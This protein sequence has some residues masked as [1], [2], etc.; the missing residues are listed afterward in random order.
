MTKQSIPNELIVRYHELV[1]QQKANA[2]NKELY[3]LALDAAKAAADAGYADAQYLYADN[4]FRLSEDR[5]RAYEYCCK[6]ALQGHQRALQ[7]LRER[8]NGIG[9][10]MARVQIRNF[11][12]QEQIEKLG[13]QR[14]SVCVP[15]WVYKFLVSLL[16]LALAV[17]GL[18]FFFVK[19]WYVIGI[20]LFLAVRLLKPYSFFA[21][22]SYP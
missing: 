11:L 17:L 15:K 12:S 4:L 20:V 8:Y 6:A 3:K 14:I 22:C 18:Y 19:G 2:T 21:L 9:C 10:D 7:E 16:M 13:L 5:S 1:D